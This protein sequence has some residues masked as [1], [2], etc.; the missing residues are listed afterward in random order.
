MLFLGIE[1]SCDETSLALLEG[2]VNSGLS[3]Y[4]QINNFE[5]LGSLTSS[6]IKVH[7]QYG[8]VVPEVGAR[9]HAEQIHWLFEQL[10]VKTIAKSKKFESRDKL[11]TSISDIFVTAEPGLVSALRVGVEFAKSLKFFL[12]KEFDHTVN[13]DYVN[14]LSGHIVSC[15]YQKRLDKD[16][17]GLVSCDN[18]K[19]G[20][21][22]AQNNSSASFDIFP[23]LH[24]LVSGGNTQT[25][26]LKDSYNWEI[27]GQTLDDAAGECFD[28]IGRMLGLPYPGG[29]N[30]AKIAELKEE[31][32]FDFPISMYKS[33]SIN[34]SFSGLKTALRYFLQEAQVEGFVIQ[35]QLSNVEI[36]QLAESASLDLSPK[37]QFIKKV[38]IS[39]QFVVVQQLCKQFNKAVR[40]LS[41]RSVGLSGGVSA[42]LLLRRK[43]AEI[44]P[45][46]VLIS[47]KELTGDNAIMIALAGTRKKTLAKNKKLS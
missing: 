43:L 45:Q 12:E 9:Q 15:F 10:L 29:V 16:E 36:E 34:F 18:S 46:K 31:N 5:V 47:Q 1:T 23:H 39:V 27:V 14:H 8:G 33:D 3:F 20:A 26:L 41:P 40:Q 35:R 21:R 28:K 30:L 38:A 4:E 6:Q 17:L 13:L 25:I 11:L 42:N 32:Y 2:K 24:L 7:Q 22:Y 19:G 37:L 44:R